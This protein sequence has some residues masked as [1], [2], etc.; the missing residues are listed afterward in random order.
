MHRWMLAAVAAITLSPAV[1]TPAQATADVLIGGAAQKLSAAVGE[2]FNVTLSVTNTGATTVDG[3]AVYFGTTWGFEPTSQFSN[4]V[5]D[6]NGLRACTFDQ[7][8][9]PGKSYRLVVP[10]RVYADA[11]AP[12]GLNGQFHWMPL[13]AYTPPSGSA[14]GGGRLAIQEG[15]RLGESPAGSWQLVD[16][17]V[18]G[19]NGADLVAVGTTLSGRV[20]DVVDATVGVRNNGPA[21]LDWTLTGTSPGLVRVTIPG[22]TSVVTVPA[23]CGLAGAEEQSQNGVAQYLCETATLFK[24]NTTTNWKFGLKID[25]ATSGAAGSVEVNPACQCQRFSADLDKSNNTAQLM[26]N[27]A[28][29]NADVTA[30]SID[31]TGIVEGQLVP[32]ILNFRPTVSDNV[33]VTKL[34]TVLNQRP[35]VACASGLCRVQTTSLG[36]DIDATIT[37]RAFDAAGNHSEKS[38]VVHVDNVLPTGALSPAAGSSMRSGTMT[39]TVTGLQPDTAKVTMLDGGTRTA[40]P[41]TFT[42]DA[43]DK[44]TPPTFVITDRAGNSITRFSRYIVDDEAPV[45]DRVDFTGSYS[46]NRL[47][48]GGGWVGAFSFVKATIS[49]ES[50]IARTEWWVNGVL[51]STDPLFYWIATN[52]TAPTAAVEARVWDAA[53]NNASR[54]FVVNIDQTAPT[55]VVSPAER[56]LIRGSSYVTALNASDRSGVA[57]TGLQDPVYAGGT[58]TSVRLTAG[59][60]G[61]K[62]LTWLAIDELGNYTYVKRTV[63]VDNTAPSLSITSWPKNNAKLTRTV[64]LKASTAD[65]NR[66]AKVQLMVNGKVVATD[67]KA[68]YAFTLNPKKYGKKFTVL[69]RAYDRAG[70]VKNSTKRTYRR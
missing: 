18:T 41:W 2:S 4:C 52:I 55:M 53:G 11:Y 49:D 50:P 23:G 9:A 59:K 63:I 56:A 21:T 66:V 60:D 54:S 1:A 14:G 17:D 44:A 24:A 38:T 33:A 61:T 8:L 36:S 62:T 19:T 39:V 7:D 16:V 45:I 15:D 43:A 58:V 69:F 48:L 65:R 28:T 32:A 31:D 12:G 46:S 6:A 47:D 25:S 35:A 5:Y 22:G 20:G 27:A 51:T 10:Y 42:W 34:E 26:V 30:P 64:T 68:A 37:V 40:A 57:Y 13:S 70:N 3:V 29:G 67:T